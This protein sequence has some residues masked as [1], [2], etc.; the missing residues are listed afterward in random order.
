MAFND[1]QLVRAIYASKIPTMVAIGHE[2]DVT[3][4]EEVA[5]IRGS[6]PTDCARRL[7]PDRKDVLYELAHLEQGIAHS[8]EGVIEKHRDTLDHF[9]SMAE[10]WLEFFRLRL[11]GLQ[12]LMVSFS[13]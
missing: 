9:E 2:R 4:A 3:L 8:V 7:V 12:R 13:P 10:R 11:D 5:D 1:E 6:T